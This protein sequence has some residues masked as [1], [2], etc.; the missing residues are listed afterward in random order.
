MNATTELIPAADVRAAEIERRSLLASFS[1]RYGLETNKMMATLRS[2]VLR[3]AYNGAEPSNEQVAAF[4]IVAHHHNLNPFTKEIHGFVDKWGAIVPIVGVDGW[5]KKANEHE[6]FDGMEFLE[7]EELVTPDGGKEAPKWIECTIY[8]KDRAHPVKVREY[9]T[10]CYR[11]ALVNSRGEPKP[12]PWQTHTRRMLRHRAMIQA[13]RLAFSFAGIYDPEEGEQVLQA[14]EIDITPQAK[15]S[16]K[17]L[18]EIVD[19]LN[20]AVAA[21]D[22]KKLWEIWLRNDL[23]KDSPEQSTVWNS[24]R[25]WERSAIKKLLDATKQYQG[26]DL[27][28]WSLELIASSKDGQ[29]L[30]AAWNAIQDAYAAEDASVPD[31]V[32]LACDDRRTVVGAP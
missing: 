22:G 14:Q 15:V 31:P 18:R 5:M 3:P 13:T 26:M 29:T 2:T 12:G 19:G 17:K 24:L 32:Q 23:N 9:L 10:E 1:Q 8:R 6:Q 25:S 11:P 16:P 20:A 21:N 30:A 28:A 7:S 27:D 4:L